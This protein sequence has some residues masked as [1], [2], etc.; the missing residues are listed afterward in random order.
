[1]KKLSNIVFAL[2]MCFTM[3]LI[4]LPA[5]VSADDVTQYDLWVGG[6]QVTSENASAVTGDGI[7]GD[8][9]FDPET[10]TLTLSNATI[11]GYTEYD[12]RDVNI[13]STLKDL[14]INLVGKNA[15]GSVDNGVFSSDLGIADDE[16]NV[17]ISGSDGAELDVYANE[18]AVYADEKLLIEDLSLIARADLYD[19][20]ISGCL[21]VS[22]SKVDVQSDQ[23]NAIT[24]DGSYITIKESTVKAASKRAD[25]AV[26]QPDG[27]A[28][29]ANGDI[30]IEDSIVTATTVNEYTGCSIWTVEDIIISGSEV[31]ATAKGSSALKAG[32]SIRFKNS[33]GGKYTKIE[34]VSENTVYGAITAM[35]TDP[36]KIALTGVVI[37]TPENGSVK[38]ISTN[39]DVSVCDSEGDPATSVIIE[40][41]YAISMAELQN[42]SAA[43]MSGDTEVEAA[44]A[45]TALSVT[46]TPAS[47]YGLGKITYTDADGNKVDITGSK[48]FTMPECETTVAVT[49]TAIDYAIT[50]AEMQNGSVIVKAGEAEAQ[51]ANTGATVTVTGKPADGYQTE[52]ITYTP[53]GGNETELQLDENGSGSFTM[54]SA[55]VTIHASFKPFEYSISVSDTE[56]G[57]AE[58]I[59]N[60]T[61]EKREKAP[62]GTT[63]RVNAEPAEGYEI[64]KIT[65]TTAGGEIKDITGAKSFTMPYDA[66]TVEASFRAANYSITLAEPDH[67]TASVLADGEAAETAIMGTKITVAAE[68]AEGY[69][70]ETITYTPAGGTAVTVSAD[71]SGVYA[72]LM[73]AANVTIDVTFRAIQYSIDLQ[74]TEHGAAEVQVNGKAADKAVIGDEIAVV[75]EPDQNYEVEIITYTPKGY[76]AVDITE[77][78]AFTMPASDV[79]VYVSF[80]YKRYGI[81]VSAEHG[82][83]SVKNGSGDELKRA[84]EST[85]LMVTAEADPGYEL[86]SISY[87]PEG[88]SRTVIETDESGAGSFKMPGA[89][90]T[91]SAEF[92]AIDYTISS[93]DEDNGTVRIINAD[94]EEVSTA[95][96]DTELTLVPEPEAGYEVDSVRL[97]LTPSGKVNTLSDTYAFTMPASNIM[98]DVT[99]KPIRYSITTAVQGHGAVKLSETAAPAGTGITV[100]PAAEAGYALTAGSLKVTDADGKEIEF[101]D[102]TFVMPMSD[103]TVSA[104][105]KAKTAAGPGVYA[106]DAD[107]AIRAMTSDSDLSGSQFAPLK[108]KSTKQTKKSVTLT[109]TKANGAV[110]YV[111]YGNLCGSK[112]K[113][114]KIVTMSGKSKKLT[115]V[116]GKK[117]TKGKYYKFI[118]VAL[119]RNNKVVSASKL[120]H[121]ASA[122]TKAGNY[123]SVSVTK[124]VVKKAK[125]MK[126]GKSLKLKA[127]AVKSGKTKVKKHV[128]LRYESSNTNVATV[129][130]S[131]VVKAGKKGSCYIYAYAQNGVCKR[132]RVAVK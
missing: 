124:T 61:E 86:V 53:D 101:A 99:F 93:V 113:P 2:L 33:D 71:E 19:A 73:P 14:T 25:A 70:L 64:E 98:V 127:K 102:N 95:V 121:V 27:N 32:N 67:G 29:E 56:N 130:K 85:V 48:T 40:P 91:V 92:R 129:T 37:T 39:E 36:Q 18:D 4:V 55:N 128:S 8:V 43:V 44:V 54:P 28:V 94:E 7:T 126:A 122:G 132:I 22:G 45:G 42:G 20:I 81:S 21:E 57:T 63:L 41:E 46:A 69:A 97:I 5:K 114:V 77:A 52:K 16:G 13:Y 112:N 11:N 84:Q 50:P 88:G 74:N 68:P 123:K 3:M 34:A 6:T 23:S 100:S 103:V 59:D 108:L 131:G 65:Y 118:V 116:A 49:F 78:A 51:T 26:D 30:T 76:K 66:I 80:C 125:K 58:V 47:G 24:A 62:G 82:T 109:W 1:M 75:T 106:D 105:F 87:T 90:V 10:G 83:V 107:K 72:F 120:I 111:V 119:D 17:T 38:M 117:I 110:K 15:V 9:S 79:T 104:T 35:E 115:K 96:V 31:Y 60:T 12:G 89:D